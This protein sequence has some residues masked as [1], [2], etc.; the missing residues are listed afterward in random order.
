MWKVIL[1]MDRKDR[2]FRKWSPKWKGHFQVT[3]VFSNSAYEI[4]ELVG[5]RRLLKI[6]GK[7]LKKYKPALQE[8]KIAKE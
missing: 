8:V 1:P 5:D 6:N 7:Y 3:Q 2:A 4:E